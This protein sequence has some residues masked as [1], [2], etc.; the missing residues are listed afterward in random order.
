MSGLEAFTCAKV[1]LVILFV[2]FFNFY[3]IYNIFSV[4]FPPYSFPGLILG[5][6]IWRLQTFEEVWSLSEEEMKKLLLY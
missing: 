6:I 4:D 1:A 5:I 3:N 2:V